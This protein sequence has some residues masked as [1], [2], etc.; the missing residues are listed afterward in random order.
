M[1]TKDMKWIRVK[2]RL[3][4]MNLG[5]AFKYSE[6]VAVLTTDLGYPTTARLEQGNLGDE[7]YWYDLLTDKTFIEVTHWI[8][9]P[10]N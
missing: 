5:S 3:P 6:V 8:P 4:K 1:K 9:L 2:D 7:P 10:K